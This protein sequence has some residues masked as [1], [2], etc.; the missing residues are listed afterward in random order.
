[1]KKSL[2][3]NILLAF[4]EPSVWIQP[5]H[6][7]LAGRNESDTGSFNVT[8]EENLLWRRLRCGDFPRRQ[9]VLITRPAARGTAFR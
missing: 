8:L 1:M 3:N 6:A 7:T 9:S 4:D 5:R 2:I